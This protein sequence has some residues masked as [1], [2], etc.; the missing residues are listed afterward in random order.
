[1]GRSVAETVAHTIS[2]GNLSHWDG[3]IGESPCDHIGALAAV[4]DLESALFRYKTGDKAMRFRLI[5]LLARR[6]RAPGVSAKLIGK[7]C[8]RA[9]H[10]HM[11]PTCPR[12]NGKGVVET[13][14]K[15]VRQCGH[16]HGTGLASE[17][18][19]ARLRA[20][21]VE[22]RTY[23]MKWR[24]MFATIHNILS[25]AESGASRTIARQLERG[26]R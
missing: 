2:T 25:A 5:L 19:Q 26:R 1:M 15:V 8:D 10:E 24:Q 23:E 3:D 22:S 17:S 7:V 16:C 21:S 4:S 13:S 14:T 11:H 6:I 18:E 20:I 9:L 12:C